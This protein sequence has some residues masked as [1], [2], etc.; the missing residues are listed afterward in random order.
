MVFLGE[1]MMRD[2]IQPSSQGKVALFPGVAAIQGMENLL[3]HNT[4]KLVVYFKCLLCFCALFKVQKR[5]TI[6]IWRRTHNSGVEQHQK[7]PRWHASPPPRHFLL[8]ISETPGRT[9]ARARRRDP[10]ESYIKWA[11]S[12]SYNELFDMTPF[13]SWSTCLAQRLATG[14]LFFKVTQTLRVYE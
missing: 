5:F 11:S 3:S 1:E 9:T 14:G 12:N 7:V 2:H 4:Q 6:Q 10:T 8:K 13:P